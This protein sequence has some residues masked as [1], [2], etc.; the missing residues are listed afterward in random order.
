MNRQEVREMNR[1]GKAA[2]PKKKGGFLGKLKIEY[3]NSPMGIIETTEQS[4][5][6]LKT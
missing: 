2:Q 4:V 3:V 1:S 5:D 6:G